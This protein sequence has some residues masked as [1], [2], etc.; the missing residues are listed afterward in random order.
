MVWPVHADC[1]PAEVFVQ[2]L[3]KLLGI[4]LVDK[5]KQVGPVDVRGDWE[6]LEERFGSFVKF[7]VVADPLKSE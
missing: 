2:N 3:L 1:H 6:N 4:L 7:P 5:L